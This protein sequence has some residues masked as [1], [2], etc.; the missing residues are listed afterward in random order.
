MHPIVRDE[1]YR[2]SYEAIRNACTHSKGTRLEV[3]LNY[4]QDL[5]VRVR[6]NGVGI[7]PFV[8]DHGREGHFGLQGMRERAAR[9]GSK[10]TVVSSP[11]AGT[12]VTLVVP[13]RIIY[14][15][16]SAIAM[17]KIKGIFRRPHAVSDSK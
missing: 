5:N 4:S 7:D 12:E 15:K 2:I 17:E 10:L 14:R 6:D 16:T 1:I 3:G 13:G 9:I 8:L 11:N